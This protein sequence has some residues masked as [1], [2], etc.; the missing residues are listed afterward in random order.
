MARRRTFRRLE[1]ALLLSAVA[2]AA[3]SELRPLGVDLAW[4]T[5]RERDEDEVLPWNHL[6]SGLAKEW[7]W[8]DWL[9]ALDAREQDDCR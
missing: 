6:D 8:T 2:D 7:L 1:R 3:E 9:D 4:F 5:T